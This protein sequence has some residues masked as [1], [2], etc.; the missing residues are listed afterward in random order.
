MQ[1]NELNFLLFFVSGRIVYTE[2]LFV[3]F[4][5]DFFCGLLICSLCKV[6]L[7]MIYL[8]MHNIFF[9]FMCVDLICV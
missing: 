6:Y 7:C 4:R 3:A 5:V 1:M 8:I 2:L 9:L